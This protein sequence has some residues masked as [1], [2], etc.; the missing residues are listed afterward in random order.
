VTARDE[1][2]ALALLRDVV[3]VELPPRLQTIRDV[4]V[5]RGKLGLPDFLTV[6]DPARRGVWLPPENLR[7]IPR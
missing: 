3:G 7:G 5:D 4:V 1:A 6:G 2:D